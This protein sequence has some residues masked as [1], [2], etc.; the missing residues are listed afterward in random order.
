MLAPEITYLYRQPRDTASNTLEITNR[1]VE[2]D[3]ADPAT[4]FSV[5]AHTVPLHDC[6]VIGSIAFRVL[7]NN[8]VSAGLVQNFYLRVLCR[9]SGLTSTGHPLICENLVRLDGAVDLFFNRAFATFSGE[10]WAPGGSEIV[11]IASCTAADL[12]SFSCAV[13]GV[14]IPR[15][16]VA[17]G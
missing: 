3:S 14:T 17:S 4:V 12:M 1:R 11:F 15:A 10:F 6:F 7:S 8:V 16:N 5:V 9:P 2:A 13:N